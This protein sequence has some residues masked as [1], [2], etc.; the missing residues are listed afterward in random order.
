MGGDGEP[1]P[2]GADMPQPALPDPAR[3]RLD[4]IFGDVLPEVTRDEQSDAADEP[5]A[6]GDEALLGCRYDETGEMP[7]EEAPRLRDAGGME[8]VRRAARRRGRHRSP[9]DPR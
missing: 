4:E 7:F 6:A 5:A 3:R 2:Q 1:D 8:R 9:G